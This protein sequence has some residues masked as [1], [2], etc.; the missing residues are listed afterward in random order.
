M[1]DLAKVVALLRASLADI[2]AFAKRTKVHAVGQPHA[3]LLSVEGRAH[4]ALE[5][6]A[7]A[8]IDPT[9]CQQQVIRQGV[10]ENKT[11]PCGL[12]R[13]AGI[14]PPRVQSYPGA[15]IGAHIPHNFEAP[16]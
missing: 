16:L 6:T 15:S 5:E 14:H 8:V 1:E 9:P 4:S 13:D 7:L 11:G 10:F 2:E 12:P 3:A